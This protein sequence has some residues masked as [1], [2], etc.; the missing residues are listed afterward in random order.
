MSF[1]YSRALVEEFSQ[2]S[3]SATDASALLNESH[4][5]KP[6]LWLDKTMEHSPLSR[7]GM[8]CRHLTDDLGAELL[9]WWREG[10]PART[11]ASQELEPDLTASDQ[12]CGHTWRGSLAK[13]DPA[14]HSLRTAQCSLFE[15][16]IVS[17]VTLPRWGLMR[18]GA[19]YPQ[20]IAALPMCESASGYWPTPQA[21]DNRDRGN[22]STPSVARRIEKG[23][24]ISL[25]M[26]V[27]HESGRLNPNW[28]EWLMAWPIGHTDLKPLETDK[29]QFAPLQHSKF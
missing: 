4:T 15:D 29:F 16:S 22:M 17:F 26:S 7:F 6:C 11:L 23:K 14:T 13:Y 8:T 18:A 21:S 20:P 27:S 19:L 28:V 12:A 25:S 1:I 3:C 2:V 10:F 9:T 24:Q 5:R